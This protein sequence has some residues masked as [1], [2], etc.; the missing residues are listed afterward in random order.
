MVC[1]KMNI[2]TYADE[3]ILGT[4]YKLWIDCHITRLLNNII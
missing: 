4:G 3:Q 2:K 1:G